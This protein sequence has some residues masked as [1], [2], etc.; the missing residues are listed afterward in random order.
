ML[1]WCRA[2]DPH[3]FSLADTQEAV[4][5]AFKSKASVS[6]GPKLFNVSLLPGLCMYSCAG[7]ALT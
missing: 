7:R 2:Y 4:K 5:A 3:A 6:Q 1:T